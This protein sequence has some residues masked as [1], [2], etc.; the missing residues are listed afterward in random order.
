MGL[1]VGFTPPADASQ[2]ERTV[3]VSERNAI[4]IG[5]DR[6]RKFSLDSSGATRGRLLGAVKL[7]NREGGER[8]ASAR[9]GSRWI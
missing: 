5:S 7:P 8:N 9:G 6:A 3:N 4:F 1:G 2:G